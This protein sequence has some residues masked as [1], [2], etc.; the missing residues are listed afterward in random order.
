M[1]FAVGAFLLQ[2]NIAQ[3]RLLVRAAR[4]V[5]E[6]SPGLSGLIDGATDN[7]I[8]FKLPS[9]A[10]TA[11][12]AF[13]CSS[14]GGRGYPISTLILDEAAHFHDN[15]EGHQAADRV[16]SAL[17][18]ATA[19]FGN[20][21]RVIVSSTPFGSDNLFARLY[22]EADAGELRDATAHHATTAEMNPTITPDFLSQEEERDPDGFPAEYLAEFVGSGNT[23]IDFSRVTITDN[24]VSPDEG[25]GWIVALDPAFA[26]DDFGVAVVGVDR[27]DPKQLVIGHIDTLPRH[28]F[29]A[30][31]DAVARIADRFS[32]RS[33]V[34]D[35]F[36]ATALT[37]RL[38]EKGLGVKVLVLSGQS[39]TAV[40]TELKSRLYEGSLALPD[41]PPLLAELRRLRVKYSGAAASVE[42]P[43][44]GGS[45]GDRAAALALGVYQHRRAGEGARRP[46]TGGYSAVGV[47]GESGPP[48]AMDM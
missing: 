21:A 19:Q 25:S 20:L 37:E 28:G 17:T 5:V 45:H 22:A 40:F 48:W 44:V 12:I 3:A 31:V 38:R 42:A 6:N 7:E 9:G 14:R 34:T 16:F 8:R 10:R 23:Y 30:A 29:T 39:K 11:L 24:T 1:E 43:R 26:S 41:D 13:P 4:S 46:R 33:V 36:S 15:T 27:D 35:Q 47:T 2:T 18:P 32:T